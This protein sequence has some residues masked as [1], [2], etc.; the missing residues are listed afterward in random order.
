MSN[1]KEDSKDMAD[2]SGLLSWELKDLRASWVSWVSWVGAMVGGE[3]AVVECDM[4]GIVY[5]QTS[6]ACII[7]VVGEDRKEKS[8]TKDETPFSD[9]TYD[10]QGKVFLET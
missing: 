5:V 4:F 8:E 9:D 3:D 1:R 7:R 10:A 6:H 2:K